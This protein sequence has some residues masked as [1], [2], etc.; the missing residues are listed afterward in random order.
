MTVRHMQQHVL[1]RDLWLVFGLALL[2]RLLAALPQTTPNYMDAA[3]YLV[4]GQRLTQGY[5]FSDPYVWH[6]LDQ[7]QALPH[8]SHLYW[9]PLPSIL[10][11]ISQM[12]FGVNYRAA[13]IPFVLFSAA[14]PVLAYM[15]AQRVS[16]VRRHGWVAALLTIFSPFY[17]P[18]WGVPE[19]FAPFAM[20]GALAL[21]WACAEAKW[22]WLAAGACAGLAH[23]SRADGVL[24]LLP[25]LLVQVKYHD[26]D[27]RRKIFIPHSCPCPRHGRGGPPGPS[28]LLILAGYFMIMMPWFLRNLNAIGAPLSSAG[29]ETI[30]LCNYDELFAYGQR[31]DLNHLLDCGNVLATRFNG[32]VSGAVHWLA[33]A[34]VIFL[35]PLIAIGLWQKRQARL[36]QAALWYALLLFVS[37][38]LVFTFAGDRGGLFHSTGALLPFC[39]AAAPIG[40]DAIID[41]IARRRRRWNAATAKKVFSAA[42]VGYAVLLSFVVYRGRVIG[43]DWSDP[44]W[45]QSDRVYGAIGQWLRDRGEIDPIVMVNNPPGFTYPTGLRSIVVPY[46]DVTAVLR[47]ADQFGA[48]WLV[49]DANRP[50]P[51]A[52]LY[53]N[54]DSDVHL[55]LRAK[56]DAVIV[57]EIT[58]D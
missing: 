49:L 56:F 4:G 45:N 43:P 51:L 17:L 12:I 37:M 39:Y 30:W 18:Y 46:G 38:T 50:E 19:S 31:F 41:W 28:L 16:G 42:F 32:L 34:G 54:P 40:L 20:F 57:L 29:T 5:G 7:P 13:Q 8:P 15:I 52:A 48:R 36:F 10:T 2:V 44:I 47:A 9:M 53:A 3:Y 23:L 6:Y 26:P 1:R 22:K 21:Y 11:A 58:P 33:E 25:M 14:L 27:G 35:A 55:A 24:L